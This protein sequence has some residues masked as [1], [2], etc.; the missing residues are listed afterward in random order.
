MFLNTLECFPKPNQILMF[1]NISKLFGM[2]WNTFENRLNVSEHSWNVSEHFSCIFLEQSWNF[3]RT[4]CNVSKKNLKVL[5]VNKSSRTLLTNILMF[6]EHSWNV[7]NFVL[8]YFQNLFRNIPK[9]F[10]MFLNKLNVSEYF[11]K[12]NNLDMLLKQLR[13][14]RNNLEIFPEHF[15]KY[16]Q[17]KSDS[18][19][20]N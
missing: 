10:G 4:F 7:P 17:N 1:Q 19:G 15:S 12:L 13:M 11:R 2:I 6:P 18:F 20:I 3:S 9:H 16:S 8:K 5:E 14:F